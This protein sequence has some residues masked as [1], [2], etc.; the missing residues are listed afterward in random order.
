MT[1]T[2]SKRF[3]KQLLA[4]NVT[5]FSVRASGP[6]SAIRHNLEVLGAEVSVELVP[7]HAVQPDGRAFGAPAS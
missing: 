1:H 5:D 2:E 3:V 4:H 6:Y 7:Q